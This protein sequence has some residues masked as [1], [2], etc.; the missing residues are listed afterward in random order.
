MFAVG[1]HSKATALA[2]HSAQKD[3]HLHSSSRHGVCTSPHELLL[4][5]DAQHHHS[6]PNADHLVSEHHHSGLHHTSRLATSSSSHP[7]GYAS[8][9]PGDPN[10]FHFAST[11]NGTAGSPGLGHPLHDLVASPSKLQVD[12]T[13]GVPILPSAN[14]EVHYDNVWRTLHETL[15]SAS[16]SKTSSV[17]HTVTILV[18]LISVCTFV[19]QTEPDLAGYDHIQ[20]FYVVEVCCTV[21]FTFEYIT[22]VVAYYCV[23]GNAW[24]LMLTPMKLCDFFATIPFYFEM[25]LEDSDDLRALRMLRIVRLTRL[26]RVL[27]LGKYSKGVA[28]ISVVIKDSMQTL[29][30]LFFLL[31]VAVL[32][33]SSLLFYVEKAGCPDRERMSEQKLNKYLLDCENG[34]AWSLQDA[35]EDVHLSSSTLA[36][37][38][39]SERFAFITNV[40]SADTRG[41]FPGVEKLLCCSAQENGGTKDFPS[42]PSAIWFTFVSMFTVG[43]GDQVPR[44]WIGY[45][46]GGVILLFGTS[47]I[48]LPVAV[49]GGKFQELYEASYMNHVPTMPENSSGSY[50]VSGA[51]NSLVQVEDQQHL[52]PEG[53]LAGQRATGFPDGI[54]KL[55]DLVESAD[56]AGGDYE[57][58]N[59][60]SSSNILKTPLQ[61]RSRRHSEVSSAGS[62]SSGHNMIPGLDDMNNSSGVRYASAPNVMKHLKVPGGAQLLNAG[63]GGSS[64]GLH[65]ANV[66]PQSTGAGD[67][68]VLSSRSNSATPNGATTLAA[69]AAAA[70]VMNN[71]EP[72]KKHLEAPL[73]LFANNVAQRLKMSK[74]FANAS[75]KS[76]SNLPT[77]GVSTSG[78]LLAAQNQ[79]SLT[80]GSAASMNSGV[81]D[82]TAKKT[83]PMLKRTISS[84][85][86][87]SHA[88]SLSNQSRIQYLRAMAHAHQS[89]RKMQRLQDNKNK[90]RTSLSAPPVGSG[91]VA[92]TTL[93]SATEGGGSSATS[94]GVLSGPADH[95]GQNEFEITR[96]RSRTSNSSGSST[97]RHKSAPAETTGAAEQAQTAVVASSCAHVRVGGNQN[98]HM[99]SVEARTLGHTPMVVEEKEE[100]VLSEERAAGSGKT[101][102]KNFL[103]YSQPGGAGAP[104]SSV[105]AAA[106][107]ASSNDGSASL[108]PVVSKTTTALNYNGGGVP[109]ATSSSSQQQE[110]Q[111]EELPARLIIR[112]GRSREEHLVKLKTML[113]RFQIEEY[114]KAQSGE[115]RHHHHID[116]SYSAEFPGPSAG[117]GSSHFGSFGGGSSKHDIGSSSTSCSLDH[118]DPHHAEQLEFYAAQSRAIADSVFH[119]RLQTL[120]ELMEDQRE[121]GP[122][123]IKIYERE[124]ERNTTLLT[125]LSPYVFNPGE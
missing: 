3:H 66:T 109:A 38:P 110:L 61:N 119:K 93:T 65:A 19:L 103:F 123:R 59:N 18:I 105:P 48:T 95:G 81:G 11:P 60:S 52:C 55:P 86:L 26:F 96:Q 122:A 102:S 107:S 104:G 84:S 69:A 30:V 121:C 44:T 72:R 118:L 58:I 25:I 62:T 35:G 73:Q 88:S 112:T 34:S 75:S 13:T 47:L 79:Q 2:F 23:H 64:A 46:S 39:Y 91:G 124:L 14:L 12:E 1:G 56:E 114:L 76:S 74:H 42:I 120:L 31:I 77:T 10:A 116:H 106:S 20:T 37:I 117:D 27:K 71:P 29:L 94:A 5:D 33:F 22:S 36:R 57:P 92:A 32:C 98:P 89:A 16:F 40:D 87:S 82:S 80:P 68:Q 99:S 51:A 53:A 7:H 24:D 41:Q 100:E 70:A 4:D 6:S 8:S 54:E 17:I 67:L 50:N 111:Q 15:E 115:I 49:I 97:G 9:S 28:L 83:N 125:N 78:G 45:I 101:T 90:K 108:R 63:A 113:V 85:S 43:Y 21:F